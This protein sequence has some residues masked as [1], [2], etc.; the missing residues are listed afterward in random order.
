MCIVNIICIGAL[1][2]LQLDFQ[3]PKFTFL[4]IP[5]FP[6]NVS[7]YTMCMFANSLTQ[8]PFTGMFVC[9]SHVTLD[10]IAWEL[11]SSSHT[12]CHP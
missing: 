2:V 8:S 3:V 11:G 7:V 9:D 4:D 1:E 12:H 5:G 10:I 6:Q